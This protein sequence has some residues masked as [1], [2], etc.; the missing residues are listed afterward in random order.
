MA[1]S[2]QRQWTMMLLVLSVALLIGCGGGG[3]SGGKKNDGLTFNGGSWESNFFVEDMFFGRPL[4]DGA[5]DRSAVRR[6]QP[7]T[8]SLLDCRL[9]FSGFHCVGADRIGIG[10]C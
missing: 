5:G 10:Q 4:F 7:D 9:K 1:I 6:R 3:S 2:T 8:S